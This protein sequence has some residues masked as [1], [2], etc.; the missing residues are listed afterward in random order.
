MANSDFVLR[1]KDGTEIQS[2]NHFLVE[3]RGNFASLIVKDVVTNDDAEYTVKA[4]NK[5]G[6][7]SSTGELFVNSSGKNCLL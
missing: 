5:A 6:T 7:A 3:V 2:D 1:Y 4:F